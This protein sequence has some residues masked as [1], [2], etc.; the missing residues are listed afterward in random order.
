V[1]VESGIISPQRA[2][3]LLSKGWGE[4]GP[5]PELEPA[6]ARDPDT[7]F[8]YAN[9]Y[10]NGRFPLGEKVIAQSPAAAYAYALL[11]LKGRFP[12]GEE[13]ILRDPK[14]GPMYQKNLD[15]G[16]WDSENRKKAERSER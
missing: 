2:Y 9:Y 10:L 7:A 13:A 15:E 16:F 11:I 6:L 1:L 8:R 3:D 5:W 12:E 4:E 14:Y